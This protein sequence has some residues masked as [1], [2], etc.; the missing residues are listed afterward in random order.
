MNASGRRTPIRRRGGP[1]SNAS[2]APTRSRD[3]C[4]REP[5]RLFDR[6]DVR[7]GA[8]RALDHRALHGLRA[9]LDAG[10][11]VHVIAAMVLLKVV[12]PPAVDAVGASGLPRRLYMQVFGV[13]LPLLVYA[14]LTGGWVTR[15]R[16][17]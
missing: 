15:A 14:F 5:Q 6:P 12:L 9:T 7:R 16:L 13:A 3:G 8:A 10:A 4:A 17:I 11:I 2:S 1:R